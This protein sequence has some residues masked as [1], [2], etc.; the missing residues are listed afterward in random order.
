MSRIIFSIVL[1][2]LLATLLAPL[3]AAQGPNGQQQQQGF[4]PKL[5]QQLNPQNQQQR[6]FFSGNNSVQTGVPFIKGNDLTTQEGRS[7]FQAPQMGA[8]EW[9]QNAAQGAIGAA[10]GAY[11]NSHQ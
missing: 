11:N 9:F 1:V 4:F 8:S 5:R 7:A 10:Q 6:N 3:A 2:T